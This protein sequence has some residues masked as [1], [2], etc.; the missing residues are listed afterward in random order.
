MTDVIETVRLALHRMQS[1]AAK[2]QLDVSKNAHVADD[3]TWTEFMCDL[4]LEVLSPYNTG[5][6]AIYTDRTTITE[7]NELH[8]YYTRHKRSVRSPFN[9]P[10]LPPSLLSLS[11]RLSINVCV[12]G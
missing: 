10:S 5:L 9:P 4:Y 1:V 11:L 6:K 8:C 3:R 2:W 7:P 12:S